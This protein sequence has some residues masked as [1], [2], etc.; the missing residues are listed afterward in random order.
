MTPD[1]QRE[2]E[3]YAEASELTKA[4]ERTAFLDQHCGGDAALRRRLEALLA[5][6]PAADGFFGPDDSLVGR[7]VPA[8]STAHGIEKVESEA[9]LGTWIGRYR[10]IEKLGE[11]AFGIVYL[12]D[13]AQP[14]RR[15]VALKIIKIGMDTRE[16]VARFNTERQALAL[17][18]HPN[19]ARV[20]DA[21]ETDTGRPYFVMEAVQGASLTEFS[22]RHRMAIPE[23]VQLFAQVCRAV[24]HAHTKGIIHRD[25]KP[26]NV[27][28]TLHEGKPLPKVIDF[29]V[30][31]AIRQPSLD[32]AR[33]TQYGQLI[34]T[35]AYMS[36]EQAQLGEAGVDTRADIY[37]L[38]VVLYEL[39]TGQLPFERGPWPGK[40]PSASDLH[41]EQ[42]SPRP[43]TRLRK[44]G[45]RLA[46][47]AEKRGVL[48]GRLSQCVRRELDW[49]VG[50]ALE[51]QP[52]R[53]YESAGALAQDLERYLRDEAVSA[54]PPS[55]LYQVTKFV[56]R[57]RYAVLVLVFAV[58]LFQVG[59]VFFSRRLDL[60]S[61]GEYAL[62]RDREHGWEAGLVHNRAYA[63][64][65][66]T[67][68][69]ALD[70]GDL[71]QTKTFLRR[72]EPVRGQ[73]DLRGW[74]WR[75]LWAQCISG[76][77]G[78]VKPRT[79]QSVPSSA[80]VSILPGTDAWFTDDD[81]GVFVLDAN[82]AVVR[83]LSPDLSIVQQFL[84]LGANHRAVGFSAR[85]HLLALANANHEVR[86]WNWARGCG[87]TNLSYAQSGA[88]VRRLEFA[89]RGDYLFAV[90]GSDAIRI[91][92]TTNWSETARRQL[93][94]IEPSRVALSP[95]G[96]FVASA[97]RD[98]PMVTVH[99]LLA[100]KE[101]TRIN[102][103]RP[104]AAVLTFTPEGGFL[105]V[106]EAG[107]KASLWD[108][109]SWERTAWLRSSIPEAT[110]LAFAPTESRLAVAADGGRFIF[111]LELGTGQQLLRLS[112]KD[113]KAVRLKFS[114]E[115]RSLLAITDQGRLH[116][117]DAPPPREL[118]D[119]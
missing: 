23:R 48:P 86:I 116:V 96:Q 13:Q 118:R 61:Y 60:A 8:G 90:E 17:M 67:A 99:D 101:M 20:I 53:R 28:V 41:S 52:S 76:T 68:A 83:L 84:A 64:N 98:L 37:S 39:L 29:G 45:N 30:A 6:Q 44:L 91:W 3:L 112:V 77:S 71:V 74:E 81:R 32:E 18:D 19:I 88:P 16:V 4:Q 66:A 49:I 12:A 5:L 2:C 35:P 70:V 87:V 95:S 106:I 57:H 109:K 9:E 56:K 79:T 113:D 14:I 89:A 63:A 111:I 85:R 10:L 22:D 43:S 24:Q 104:G 54:G 73:G 97:R 117:W 102:L 51:A 38:G 58:L 36:P 25:L 62:R 93:P 59:V 34:G 46:E 110:C 27:L 1:S 100:E 103:D 80:A 40:M 21:G 114:P 7:S 15:Q 50:K 31:K 78:Q 107:G 47:V 92:N 55:L 33:F 69:R 108:V 65:I 75:Y 11:G 82:G 105:A 72:S 119:R 115:G 94:F 26:S 42:A